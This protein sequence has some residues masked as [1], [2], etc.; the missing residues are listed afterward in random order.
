MPTKRLKTTSTTS[1]FIFQRIL[2]GLDHPFRYRL[3]NPE[4]LVRASGITVGQIVLEIGCGSGFFTESAAAQVGAQ[5]QLHAIDAH[6]LAVEATARKIE[7]LRL[8]NAYVTCADAHATGFTDGFFDLILLYGVIPAPGIIDIDRLT[9]EM[10][11]LLKPAGRVA[12]WTAVPLWSPK[13]VTQHQLLRYLGKHGG[14]HQFQ[15]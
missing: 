13:S 12:V 15:K 3:T 2:A 5:G 8:R 9:R 6:P 1:Q 10:S 14:V 7:E 4:K 11:R